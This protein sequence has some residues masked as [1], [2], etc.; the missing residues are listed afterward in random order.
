M[1][2]PTFIKRA[3][4][5]SPWMSGHRTDR[6]LGSPWAFLLTGLIL[7]VIFG[8]TFVTNPD[9]PA[10]ADDPA[11]YTWR[12]EALLSNEPDAMLGIHGP[13]DMYSSGYR[14]TTPVIGGLI[15][16]IADVGPLTPTIVLSVGLRVLIPMLLAGFAYSHRRDPL[17]WHVVAIGSASLL[18]T[19]PFAGYLDNVM[20]LLFL[21]AS[22]YLLEPM[23]TRWSARAGF[24]VLLLL[25][26]M[27][28]PTTLAIFCVVLGAM[29]VVRLIYRRFDLRSVIRDDA[30]M[31]TTAFLAAVGTYVIWKVGIWGESASLSEAALPPPAGADFFK[32]RLGDWV[33]AM[34]PLL[35]APL[36]LIGLVG[37]LAAGRDAAEDELARVGVVWLAPLAGVLGAVAGLTYPYYR[38]F[39]TTLAWVLLVGVGAY[40]LARFFL[41]VARGGGLGTIA[42]LG[43]VA[44]AAVFA[45]NFKAG[46]DQT[47][48]NDPADA[49]VKPDQRADLD[50]LRA[51]ID[52]DPE[53]ADRPVIFIADDDAPEPVRIYGFAKLVGNVSRYGV[54]GELQD[55]TAYYLGSLENFLAGRPTDRDDYYRSLSEASLEDAQKVA[56]ELSRSALIVVADV[57]NKTG[58]NADI[59]HGTLPPSGADVI[60]LRDGQVEVSVE[61]TTTIMDKP[62]RDGEGPEGILR[63]LG[64]ALLLLLPGL[65][66]VRYLLPGASPGETIAMVPVLGISLLALVTIVQL[67][68]TGS[69]LTS[70]QAWVAWTI[71][72]A[73][74]GLAFVLGGRRD[75]PRGYETYPT[76][77]A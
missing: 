61:D 4:P 48:W 25:S 65:L 43:L 72:T 49:W 39:N 51:F 36:F 18:V 44:I 27:T 33:G 12:T 1:A 69:A 7:V 54:P 47:H 5:H 52:A 62:T 31:L 30:A 10:A 23:R 41:G 24:F 37:L 60:F 71:A 38:F 35:N 2:D 75:L 59:V 73:L 15:R 34:R 66:L 57:F 11:Y 46:L 42:V 32:T 20:T 45:G 77:D 55:D 3:Q 22:L 9:R 28:H 67:G 58:S 19:P 53:T 56:P 16:R 21:T 68:V 6:G 13:L 64:G 50:A 14:V 74:S 40:F 26:G 63:A 29:A 17:I 8:A 76:V 70:G